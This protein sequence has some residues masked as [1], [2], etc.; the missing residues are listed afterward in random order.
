MMTASTVP[1]MYAE[2][3]P[4]GMAMTNAT[5]TDWR[6]TRT[7]I[8]APAMIRLKM[9]RPRSSV[10]S[11]CAHDGV[12]LRCRISIAFGLYGS[13]SEP[14]TAQIATRTRKAMASIA[15]RFRSSFPSRRFRGLTLFAAASISTGA[16]DGSPVSVVASTWLT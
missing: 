12:A 7:A 15:P 10:P 4:I 3:S 1:P 8:A 16:R 11:Q 13:R 9:S 6:L 5:S 2:N 14:N